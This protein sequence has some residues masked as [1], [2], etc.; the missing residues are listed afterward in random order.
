MMLQDLE[1]FIQEQGPDARLVPQEFARLECIFTLLP[2]PLSW[3]HIEIRDLQ[4]WL[5]GMRSFMALYGWM[6]ADMTI[7]GVPPERRDHYPDG[8]PMPDMKATFRIDNSHTI[9]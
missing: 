8:R 9:Q 4:T 5:I 6:E 2:L 3:G 7:E 1:L